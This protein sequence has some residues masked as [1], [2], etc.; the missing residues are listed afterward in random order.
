MTRLFSPLVKARGFTLIEV[1]IALVVTAVGLLGL[2]K[3][4]ALAIS[5]T[6]TSGNRSLIALQVG[7]L[8]SAMHANK[9]F[10]TSAAVPS[11]FSA[12][13]SVVSDTSGILNATVAGGCA[14]LCT[15]A[16]MAANDVQVWAADMNKQ[17]PSYTAKVNC[18]NGTNQPV[19]C[20][21]YVT[22][23]ESNVA[24]SQT[25]SG[26]ASSPAPSFSVFVKP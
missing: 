23:T 25:S 21:I 10:W 14:S 9:A 7:S 3:M 13:T 1:L 4:Q 8:V 11:T 22:W 6:K 12:A 20:Q 2:A 17:F 19:S 24:L 26:G 15:P 5:S 16:N 18:T